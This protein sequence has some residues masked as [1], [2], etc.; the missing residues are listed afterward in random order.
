MARDHEMFDFCDEL[1]II[2]ANERQKESG[3]KVER[4]PQKCKQFSSGSFC[5]ISKPVFV[6]F[7]VQ[8]HFGNSTRACMTLSGVQSRFRLTVFLG[9]KFLEHSSQHRSIIENCFFHRHTDTHEITVDH[10]RTQHTSSSGPSPCNT[11]T[12]NYELE[13]RDL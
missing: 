10:S 7:W 9:V 5:H 12:H 8:I 6:R 2:G 4:V 13:G 11:S 3:R 1:L